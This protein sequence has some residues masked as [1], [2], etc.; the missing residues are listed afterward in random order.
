MRLECEACEFETNNSH[1]LSRHYKR[2]HTNVCYQNKGKST[3]K[4][5]LCESTFTRQNGLRRHLKE[6]H[7]KNLTEFECPHCQS[8][9]SRKSVLDL[10]VG[11]KHLE[12]SKEVLECQY[13]DFKTNRELFLNHHVRHIHT[14][15]KDLA[16]DLCDFKTTKALYM[17]HH[18]ER[19]HEDKVEKKIVIRPLLK[20]SECDFT[21]K[22][23]MSLGAHFGHTHRHVA[24]NPC[25]SCDVKFATRKQLKIHTKTFCHDCG[26]KGVHSMALKHHQRVKHSICDEEQ[27]CSKC[28]MTFKNSK[29][30]EAHRK[31]FCH[32]C[33]FKAQ[34]NRALKC[35][36]RNGHKKLKK[37]KM[38]QETKEEAICDHCDLPCPSEDILTMH[39]N[40]CHK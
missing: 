29:Q 9:F 25:T 32:D 17:K 8:K 19:M 12:K 39:I 1:N 16:C 14:N 5:N 13:C 34:H 6:V 36:I 15:K 26:F 31:T 7:K 40:L 28:D 37:P 11:Y 2:V 10:H 21:A 22:S 3:V 30:T 4:C 24:Q 20:C 33:G 27:K 18:M 35:H 23:Q 38:I